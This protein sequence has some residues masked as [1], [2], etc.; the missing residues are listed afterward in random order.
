MRIFPALVLSAVAGIAA[1]PA[2]AQN[3][4]VFGNS[5][6]QQ[7][8]VYTKLPS[9]SGGEDYCNNALR[10]EGLSKKDRAATL[11]NRGIIYNRTRRFAQAFADF[12]EALA[13]DA[14]LGEAYVNRGNTYIFQKDLQRAVD[15]YSKAIEVGTKDL[16]AAYYNRGLAYEGLN[17]LDLAFTD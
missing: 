2:S 6:A 4:T 5:D 7:C 14:N 9:A 15:D 10:F 13:I 12:E 1:T 17:E 8:Y 11:V 3:V 16:H